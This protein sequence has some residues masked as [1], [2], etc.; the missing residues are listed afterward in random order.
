MKSKL[1]ISSVLSASMFLSSASA[2]VP[3][4]PSMMNLYS[5]IHI[6][7][8]ASQEDLDE[9]RNER[10]A[11]LAQAQ[12]AA[13]RVNDLNSQRAE[14]S[15]QLDALNAQDEELQV[16]YELLASQYAAALIA[17][18]EALN[19][20]VQSQDNLAAAELMFGERVSVM[21]EYQNKSFLEILL[22]SDSI[23]G[24][25]T[26]I[27]LIALIAEADDQA[28]DQMQI[29]LDDARL[30]EETALAEAEEMEEVAAS[31]QAE[32]RELEEQIGI[33]TDSIADLDWQ[34][35][36]AQA[37][38]AAFNAQVYD[39][40]NQIESI[41]ND[42]YSQ[43]GSDLN[44]SG[45]SGSTN[46]NSA[47]SNDPDNLP[48]DAAPASESSTD[49]STGGTVQWPTYSRDIRSTFGY[50][51]HPLSNEWKFHGGIDIA[52]NYGD[53]I[54]AAESGTVSFVC[55]P[56]PGQNTSDPT[57]GGGYGNYLMIDHGNGLVTLYAHCRNIYVSEGD[58][59]TCGQAIAEVGS[60]GSSTDPHL[61][62]EVRINGERKNPIDY[63]P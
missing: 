5:Q 44:N 15:G 19:R 40:N 32:L 2:V 7:R 54:C 12:A 36:S 3:V 42:L 10:D 23:S 52:N 46:N 56:C 39:L 26:N 20:Y 34:I 48:A 45:P 38:A 18:A 61:H 53:T 30:Q 31:K 1:I 58:Y 51:E 21:F 43:Y 24:F 22:E 8:E 49:P 17:K 13:A 59:V 55:L 25:F 4:D 11:A 33:T 60:T 6:Q 62:F 27:E 37:D 9:R 41:Q 14:L 29:A 28:V 47:A 63:L 57:E 35:S 50:R 16:E